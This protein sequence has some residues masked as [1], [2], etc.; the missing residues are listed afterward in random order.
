VDPVV[1]GDVDTFILVITLLVGNISDQFLMD[2]A[3]DIR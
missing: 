3:P 2:T 1:D